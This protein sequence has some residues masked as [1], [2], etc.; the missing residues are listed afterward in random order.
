MMEPDLGANLGQ[1]QAVV[2]EAKHMQ[3]LVGE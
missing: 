3:K 2:R 1:P